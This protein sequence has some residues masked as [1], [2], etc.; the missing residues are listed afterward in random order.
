[1]K[2]DVPIKTKPFLFASK[3]ILL[4]LLLT[5]CSSE[6]D[7]WLSQDLSNG[8]GILKVGNSETTGRFGGGGWGRLNGADFDKDGDIDILANFGRGG[9][10][11][12]TF[13]GLYFYENIGSPG[14]ALLS[15]GIKLGDKEGHSFVG[16]AN[17][18]GLLDI[19]CEGEL[20]TNISNQN[21]ITFDKPIPAK[22]P[23]WKPCGE[24]DWD[25]DGLA[26]RFITSRW[27]LEMVTGKDTDTLRLP[28]GGKEILEDI[29]IRPFVCDWDSDNDPDLLIGQE[30]GHITFIENESGTLLQERHILQKNPNVK[31]GC[32][33][34]PALCDWDNDGDIDIIVGTAAG[35]LELYENHEKK[36]QTGKKT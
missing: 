25:G 32:A 17:N 1:M 21:N 20:F 9:N 33:S 2:I 8:Y 19:F 27:H 22:N 35:F 4:S 3:C 5:N 26:D 28:V 7:K 30:S 6:K 11:V 16:D 31:S 34:V 12:G 23:G 10:A 18:D 14:N 24:T 36:I 13:A 29:F 15:E